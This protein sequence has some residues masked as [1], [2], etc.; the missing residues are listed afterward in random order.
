[1]PVAGTAVPPHDGQRRRPRCRRASGRSRRHEA[2]REAQAGPDRSTRLVLVRAGA[3]SA[4]PH[5]RSPSQSD[6]PSVANQA[7]HWMTAVSL[8]VLRADWAGS[9]CADRAPAWRT[10]CCG[11]RPT[12]RSRT[13]RVSGRRRTPGRAASRSLTRCQGGPCASSPARRRRRRAAAQVADRRADQPLVNGAS[14]DDWLTPTAPGDELDDGLDGRVMSRPGHPRV[15]AL[16]PTGGDQ[17]L[18]RRGGPRCSPAG[19]SPRR[20]QSLLT[21]RARGGC[22]TSLPHLPPGAACCAA[23]LDVRFRAPAYLV[24]ETPRRGA[25]MTAPARA[26]ARAPWSRVDLEEHP[27]MPRLPRRHGA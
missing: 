11:C 8:G 27:L 9:A 24:L 18:E 14:T 22:F 19:V 20:L 2:H 1:M 10:R 12:R 4:R 16:V 7:M 23:P 21:V 5:R 26:R 6:L 13:P 25:R 3:R 15:A 17:W